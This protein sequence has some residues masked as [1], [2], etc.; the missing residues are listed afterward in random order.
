MIDA[1]DLAREATADGEP[2]LAPIR[3]VSGTACSRRTA[4]SIE[5]ALAGIVFSDDAA[6]RDLER[7][8]H[9]AVR[10]RVLDRLDAAARGG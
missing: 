9:P 3:R 7:I 1:D 8:V 2:A 5:A 6:L 10:R 4:P